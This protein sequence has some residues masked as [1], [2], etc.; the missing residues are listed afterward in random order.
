MKKVELFGT[1][2]RTC[3]VT[4]KMIRDKAAALGVQIELV[5]VDDPAEIVSRGVI[6]IPAVMV[7]GT[8]VHKGG[9]PSGRDIETWLA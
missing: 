9:L 5:K 4:E 2:C 7:E 1:G 3:A 8:F 6:S